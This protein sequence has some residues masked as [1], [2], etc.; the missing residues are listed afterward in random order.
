MAVED[1]EA[2]RAHHEERDA[3][4]HDLDELDGQLALAFGEARDEH[5]HERAREHHTEQRDHG[6]REHEQRADGARDLGGVGSAA[7]G[8]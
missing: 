3:G 8:E 6:R 2:P 4:E 5:G 7:L 1:A